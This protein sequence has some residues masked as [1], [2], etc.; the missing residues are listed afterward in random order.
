[1]N[2]LDIDL[3]RNTPWVDMSA[4]VMVKKHKLFPS[5]QLKYSPSEFDF[6]HQMLTVVQ[7]YMELS[8]HE[9]KVTVLLLFQ[10]SFCE[11]LFLQLE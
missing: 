11:Q 3:D 7:L 2:D 10:S 4:C 9:G 8:Y 1:M 6:D 5:V